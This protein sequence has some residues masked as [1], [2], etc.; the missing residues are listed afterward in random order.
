MIE[1]SKI[2]EIIETIA[3]GSNPEQILLF[4]SYAK[5]FPNDDS[6]LDLI[7]IKESE[8]PWYERSIE[9]QKLLIG[10]KIPIDILVYTHDEFERE[11]KDKFS[12][13]NTAF[14]GT[15]LVYERKH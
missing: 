13:L 6:D 2:S 7:I 5:G 4:G 15:Q 3:K 8:K 10:T 11:K 9:I 12:F 14:Q 1:N